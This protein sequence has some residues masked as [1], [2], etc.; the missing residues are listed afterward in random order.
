MTYPDPSGIPEVQITNPAGG[1]LGGDRLEL[2][3]SLAAGSAATVCT[4]A[5]GKAYRG[6]EALQRTTL[7]LEDGALLEY[8]PHHVIPFAACR[9]RQETAMYLSSG[10]TL[11]AWE[12]VSAGRLAR[13]ERFGFHGL[14]TRTRLVR[15]GV[16]EAI[17]GCELEGG[18]EPFG[19]WSY[20]AALYVVCPQ[21]PAL[22]DGLH[23]FLAPLPRTQASASAPTRG[24]VTGRV[25]AADAPSLYRALNGSRRTV[26]EHLGLP[27]PAREIL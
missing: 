27:P 15:D 10:A 9:Y 2:E 5:A 3:V 24:V 17:D 6:A 20:L 12:G 22:A 18:G 14:S 4:Q 16:V 19:G 25:L 13:G 26:R 7:L 8:I 11:I 21:A 23:T 1:M